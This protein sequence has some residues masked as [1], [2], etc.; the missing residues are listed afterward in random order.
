MNVYGMVV[1]LAISCRNALFNRTAE[2]GVM[3]GGAYMSLNIKIL[4][5]LPGFDFSF[6]FTESRITYSFM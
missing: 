4:Q 2:Y 1:A 6:R 3:R 5:F